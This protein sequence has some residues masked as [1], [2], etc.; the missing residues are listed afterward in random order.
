MDLQKTSGENEI[1]MNLTPEEIE[2]NRNDPEKMLQ[3]VSTLTKAIDIDEQKQQKMRQLR[4]EFTRQMHNKMPIFWLEGINAN[5]LIKIFRDWC[6]EYEIVFN[7]PYSG[8]SD[9]PW[10]AAQDWKAS[11]RMKY[12]KQHEKVIA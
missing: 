8:A 3:I 1:Y 11:Q 5:T 9:Y 10:R 12:E 7:K 6:K 2:K 4:W